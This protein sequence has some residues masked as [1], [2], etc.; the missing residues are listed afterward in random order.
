M[1]RLDLVDG[2][3]RSADF[4]VRIRNSPSVSPTYDLAEGLLA[5]D[6]SARIRVSAAPHDGAD[7]A[8]VTWQ[9][10]RGSV[11]F[12][13]LN[14]PSDRSRPNWQAIVD[15]AQ[16]PEG[17]HQGTITATD[18]SGRSS[19]PV[20]VSY[21]VLRT[22]DLTLRPA[23]SDTVSD[24]AVQRFEIDYRY[25]PTVRRAYP[26]KVAVLVDGIRRA[27]DEGLELPDEA[28]TDN[29]GTATVQ[30]AYRLPPGPH[31]LAIQVTDNRGLVRTLERDVVVAPSVTA[32]W[33]RGSSTT[34]VSNAL[35]QLGA[36]VRT[37]SDV[38]LLDC[39]VVIDGGQQDRPA[40][41]TRQRDGS[42]AA[43]AEIQLYLDG[44]HA[45]QLQLTPSRGPVATLDTTLTVIP[46]MTATITEAAAIAGRR[47]TMVGQLRSTGRQPRD[48]VVEAQTRQSA[49]GAWATVATSTSGADGRV[50]FSLVTQ[51]SADFRLLTRSKSKAWGGGPGPV[52]FVKV[53]STVTTTSRP[54][55]ARKGKRFVV[56]AVTRPGDAGVTIYLQRYRPETKTWTY[57]AN[58]KTTAGGKVS[59]SHSP[60]VSATYRLLRPASKSVV[61]GSSSSFTVKVAT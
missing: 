37:T 3:Q 21:T 42:W 4:P 46:R 1:H 28:A 6:Q 12:A 51:R 30:T 45:V 48:A 5:A 8:G 7:I 56:A 22:I 26:V 24:L 29:A 14:D 52:R 60:Y 15:T 25:A 55:S 35:H 39:R 33:T 36:R 49:T 19:V 17:P 40:R 27:V 32:A 2:T 41:C 16:L 13:P 50:A 18:T 38:D 58:R 9:D 23:V 57:L 11:A 10:G 31:R 44:P 34:V 59:I 43:E 20:A 61:S 54:T 53:R 47:Y